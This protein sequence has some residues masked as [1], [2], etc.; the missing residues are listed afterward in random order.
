MISIPT[1]YDALTETHVRASLVL[2]L[3]DTDISLIRDRVRRDRRANATRYL[4]GLCRDPVYVSNSE[5]TSHFAHYSDSGPSCPWRRQSPKKLD[6]IS[7]D[8]F[9]GTQ[10]G[11][12]HRRTL[13]TL[14]ILCERS[15]GFTD[16]GVPNATLKGLP[17][18]GHRFPDLA[19]THEGRR[20]VF[21]LQISKTYLPVISDREAFYRKN[22]IYLIW[23]FHKF[24][25]LRDRQTERDI[26]ALHGRQAFE[27]DD[28]AI[29]ATLEGGQLY[30][31]AYWQVPEHDGTKIVWRWETRLV[32]IEDLTFDP[33]L[34]QTL[35]RQPWCDEASLLNDIHASLIAKFEEMWVG[36]YE[37]MRRLSEANVREFRKTGMFDET[38]TWEAVSRRGFAQLLSAAGADPELASRVS[39]LRFDNM[40]DR[41]LFLRD[42]VNRMNKQSVIGGM[43]SVLDHWPHFT[44][45][46]F[47]VG[48]AYGHRSTLQNKS[49]REK[50]L[51]NLLKPQCHDFDRLVA[52]MCPKASAWL[53]TSP[54]IAD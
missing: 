5:G 37:W 32:A 41:I 10:E 33:Y 35:V 7:A 45:M 26:V 23:L 13:Q 28:D 20:I 21:E 52:M 36:R 14:K 43:H 51:Q 44:S 38:R 1:I 49:I 29:Q 6:D 53:R 18:T 31:R 25:A 40:L 3:D 4:C 8:R 19:A 50:A 54:V 11:E 22:G 42:G 39:E 48:A 30:L 27:L 12:T 2:S 15:R 16:V 47:A 34:V 46:L 17:G 24:E 9:G